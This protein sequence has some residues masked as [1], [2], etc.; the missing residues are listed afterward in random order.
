M[1]RATW[2]ARCVSFQIAVEWF[3]K[4][5]ILLYVSSSSHRTYRMLYQVIEPRKEVIVVAFIHGARL[6]ENA[7]DDVSD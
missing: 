3:P 6:L 1:K 4:K 5:T 2:P 7:L